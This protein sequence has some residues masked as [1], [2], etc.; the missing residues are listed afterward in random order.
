MV[1]HL[2]VGPGAMGFYVY[3]GAITKLRDKGQLDELVEIAGASAGALIG[4]LYCLMKGDAKKILEYSLTIPIKDIMKPNIKN[5]LKNFG[6]IPLN[7][8]RKLL[9]SI[10]LRETLKDDLTFRELYE[11]YPI[12]LHVSAYCIQLEKTKYFSVDTTP[13]VGILDVMCASIAVPFLFSSVKLEDGLSYID[14]GSVET[15]PSGVFIGNENAVAYRISGEG[16]GPNVKDL[17]TYAISLLYATMKLR[18]EYPIRT[19]SLIIQDDA[20]DFGASSE[21]KIRMYM[22]GYSQE[23]SQ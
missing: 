20:Y 9:S 10:C 23:F 3:L 16:W 14:G 15:T 2:A 19:R 1:T 8:I 7:K 17:K 18:Y 22:S 5:I 11:F 6:L 12:K 21:S 13:E 4:L